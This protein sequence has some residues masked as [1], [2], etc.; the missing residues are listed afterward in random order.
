MKPM[1]VLKSQSAT[2]TASLIRS[3]REN[4]AGRAAAIRRQWSERERRERAGLAEQLQC[5]LLDS[6]ISAAGKSPA[7]ACVPVR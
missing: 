5:W 6:V 2:H 1:P 7:F 4:I 3:H